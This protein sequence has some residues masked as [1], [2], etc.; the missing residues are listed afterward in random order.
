MKKFYLKIIFVIILSFVYY[1]YRLY[2][3]PNCLFRLNNNN[4]KILCLGSLYSG[5]IGP[6]KSLYYTLKYDKI[7]NCFWVIKEL[8]LTKDNPIF[9]LS[10][11][12]IFIFFL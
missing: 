8:F 6:I 12:S 11:V 4:E 10:M 3:I 2:Y 7:K 9:I 5:F 1:L